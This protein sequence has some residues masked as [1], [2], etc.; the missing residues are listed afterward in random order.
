MK[1]MNFTTVKRLSFAI[2]MIALLTYAATSVRY[3]EAF[4]VEDQ[5]IDEAS[6]LA[7]S[8]QNP[9]LLY[10]HNDSGGKN[11]VYVLNSVGESL[12][13]L[14]LDGIKNRDW[15][16]IAM[17]SGPDK[18][19]S[20]IYLGE[21]GDN[22]AIH[23]SIYVYRFAEPKLQGENPG[24]SINIHEIDKLEITYEDGARDAEALFVDPQTADIYI[25]SK[26][27]EQVGLYR[28]NYPQSTTAINVARKVATLPF[29]MV[30]AADISPDGKKILVKTYT[31][32]WQW[33]VKRGKTIDAAFAANPKAMKYRI[34]PQGEAVAW[35]ARGKGYYTL[36]ERNPDYP[37][38]LYYYR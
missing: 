35:D 7:A 9:G 17:G 36:S 2:I 19:Q 27:E 12:G 21:I 15:E 29:S 24:F 6:G 26:R 37:L 23:K 11:V 5:E 31:G 1:D 34:E 13:R 33:K 22:R 30:T 38:Y 18:S 16:D 10:T 20:Y 14:V 28:V 3:P 32:V 8:R 25:I 4:L